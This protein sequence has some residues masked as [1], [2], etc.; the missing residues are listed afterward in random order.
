MHNAPSINDSNDV[1]WM[2]PIDG[3]L[4]IVSY[5]RGQLTSPD[6]TYS[7]A[8]FPSL[9]NDGSFVCS[10]PSVAGCE[11]DSGQIVRYPGAVLIEFCSRN[12]FNGNISYRKPIPQTGMSSDGKVMWGR[13]F[14]SSGSLSTRKFFLNGVQ[15]PG[16]LL[17]WNNPAV[18]AAGEYVY[19]SSGK[20][21]SSNTARGNNGLLA[22]GTDPSINDNGDVVYVASGRVHLID[23]K[24][25]GDMDIAEGSAPAINNNRVVVFEHRVAEL[26]NTTQIWEAIPATR[27]LLIDP[28]SVTEG[29]VLYQ[30]EDDGR[31]VTIPLKA[32]INGCVDGPYVDWNISID[33]TSPITGQAF[34]FPQP[35]ASSL[36]LTVADCVDTTYSFSVTGKGGDLTIEAIATVDGVEQRDTVHASIH[37]YQDQ[38]EAAVNAAITGYLRAHPLFAALA[39]PDDHNRYQELLVGL[40]DSE[41]HFLSFVPVNDPGRGQFERTTLMPY[42]YKNAAVGLMQVY[43]PVHDDADYF[44]MYWDWKENA[45][46][47]AKVLK[48]SYQSVK[49]DVYRLTR[50]WG[51]RLPTLE[52]SKVE[53]WSLGRYKSFGS[54]YLAIP[55][56]APTSWIVNPIM[57]ENPP[58]DTA[59]RAVLLN[60]ARIK[61]A[62]IYGNF[63]LDGI[64]N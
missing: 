28:D 47:G 31:T 27:P 29:Q 17:N 48:T 41:S 19:E 43:I 62:N 10:R 37:G 33:Y 45:D 63:L 1:L 12:V 7:S 46:Y 30:S 51:R 20:I 15:V 26:G 49:N 14:Y 13:E 55:P 35:G 4:Q 24:C 56:K 54:V 36:H 50:R 6:T 34:H 61:A 32:Q 9:A 3:V 52:P 44:E 42:I 18:N 25:G 5:H 2:E 38:D 22:T 40:A 64:I 16:N 11:G 58:K 8:E 53:N 39:A 57:Y 21:F 60:D 23:G 59:T